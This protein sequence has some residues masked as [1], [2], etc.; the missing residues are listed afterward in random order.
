[1]IP[2]TCPNP[3][4][5]SR[6]LAG[7]TDLDSLTEP[8]NTETPRT[9]SGR[10]AVDAKTKSLRLRIGQLMNSEIIVC[11]AEEFMSYY[12]PKHDMDVFQRVLKQLSRF[13]EDSE[14]KVL[15]P[16]DDP[17]REAWLKQRFGKGS[18]K[19]QAVKGGRSRKGGKSRHSADTSGSGSKDLDATAGSNSNATLY[20]HVFSDFMFKPSRV[21]RL[22]EIEK[23]EKRKSKKKKKNRKAKKEETKDTSLKD[24]VEPAHENT[25]FNPI[26]TIGD[27]I[28]AVLKAIGVAINEYHLRMCPNTAITSGV[29]GCNHKI[30]ACLTKN[31]EDRLSITDIIVP[32][33][34]KVACSNAKVFENRGQLVSHVV[35][36]MNDD[37]RRL[38][39]YGITIE[40]DLVSVWFFSRSHSAKATVFSMIEIVVK[41]PDLLVRVLVSLFCATDEQLGFDPLVSLVGTK[42]FLYTF[43]PSETRASTHYYLTIHSVTEY[44]SLHLR[45]RSSRVWKV[46]RVHSAK[47]HERVAGTTDMILKD[48]SLSTDTPT[49]ARIQEEMFKD[50]GELSQDADWRKRDILRNCS[51][52]DLDE[53]GEV[54]KDGTSFMKFFSCIAQ[55]HT[56]SASLAICAKGWRLPSVFEDPT[57]EVQ[58][59]AANSKVRIQL[60]AKPPKTSADA[61]LGKGKAT[62]PTESIHQHPLE[63]RH[64]FRAVYDHVYTPLHDIMTMGEAVDII[65]GCLTVLRVMFCAGWV[66]RDISAGNILAA[67]GRPRGPWQVKLADLEY[68]KRFPPDRK[69]SVAVKSMT[70]NFMPCEVATSAL[71]LS[72]V[73][74]RAKER[75]ALEENVRSVIHS[76]QHDLESIWWLFFWLASMRVDEALPRAHLEEIFQDSAVDLPAVAN[77]RRSFFVREHKQHLGI[78]R[79]LTV[80]EGLPPALRGQFL[81][82]LDD[83]RYNLLVEYQ[84]R[85]R[86]MKQ[87]DIG[88]YSQIIAD[89]RTFFDEIEAYRDQ[90][91]NIKLVTDLE[92]HQ[93]AAYRKKEEQI[94]YRET[95]DYGVLISNKRPL[96]E[97]FPVT[98]ESTGGETVEDS[99]YPEDS[100]GE[101]EEYQRHLPKKARF[102]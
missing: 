79:D 26:G 98:E 48:L 67:R 41:R 25:Q 9:S 12:L 93:R 101:D 56:G 72:G 31:R 37:A 99:D 84:K 5:P 13:P 73:E 14:D 44:R 57:V 2:A 77:P 29:D 23:L 81:E 36:T 55:H 33:E 78:H 45:G 20:S 54:L 7:K 60:S 80:C 32:F 82:S 47:N 94:V 16:R 6:N 96:S 39:M 85:N 15:I 69:A 68:A 1:M 27:Y 51:K 61:D 3:A 90:W 17:K 89:F 58:A 95:L 59:A 86:Q 30:D 52:E 4:T 28:R 102:F 46:K 43:P 65:K 83:V 70:T 66:H 88:T 22:H 11:D 35:H 18:I 75:K 91:E 97:L 40:D 42:N 10:A 64:Q 50:I 62:V 76:P 34:F 49:E 74:L 8:I 87:Q 92:L 71:L 38:F 63:P 24:D 21:K 100:D 19:E 53:M